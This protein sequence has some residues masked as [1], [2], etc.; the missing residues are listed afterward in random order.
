MTVAISVIFAYFL[1]KIVKFLMLQ[2]SLFT[3]LAWYLSFIDIYS[4]RII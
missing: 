2:L 1:N 3:I 4:F